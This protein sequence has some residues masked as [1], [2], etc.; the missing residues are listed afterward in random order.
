MISREQTLMAISLSFLIFDLISPISIPFM[1]SMI[2][3]FMAN[4]LPFKTTLKTVVVASVVAGLHYGSRMG[5]LG[6]V[7]VTFTYCFGALFW[8]PLFKWR[9]KKRK[10]RE[11]IG[12]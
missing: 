8:Y 3:G 2:M 1:F 12:K 9:F 5:L 7:A 6:V 10:I 4:L 11:R